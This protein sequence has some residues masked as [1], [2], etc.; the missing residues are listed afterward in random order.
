MQGRI[1]LPL[2]ILAAGLTFSIVAFGQEKE[3]L[4][5]VGYCGGEERTEIIGPG[6]KTCPHCLTPKEGNKELGYDSLNLPFKARDISGVYI[7]RPD[8]IG[9]NTLTI[10][11]TTHASGRKIRAGEKLTGC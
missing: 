6:W 8:S 9:P 4:C 5:A 2:I 10:I 7:S 3:R 11:D 1:V